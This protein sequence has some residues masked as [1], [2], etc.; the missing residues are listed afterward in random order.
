[1]KRST[2]KLKYIDSQ[3]QPL[4]PGVLDP[5]V[6]VRHTLIFILFFDTSF[7]AKTLYTSPVSQ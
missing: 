7:G 4:F 3:Q 1:M 2:K 5:A 6:D